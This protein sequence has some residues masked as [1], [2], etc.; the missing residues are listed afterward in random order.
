MA[1]R[2]VAAAY[3]SLE[4]QTAQFKAAIGEAGGLTKKFA[5]ET[6]EQM[7]QSRESVRLL[8]EELGLGIPRGLQGIISKLPGV[9]TAMNAAFDAVVV[10]A[11]I[12]TVVKVTEKVLE[13]SRKNEEAAKK[14][15]AAW[16]EAHGKLEKELDT[17]TVTGDK[18]DETYDKMS[19]KPGNALALAL[20]E[21][22]VTA[23]NLAE[24]L[25]T[26]LGLMDQLFKDQSVSKWQ[27]LLGKDTSDDISQDLEKHRTAITGAERIAREAVRN[28]KTPE[29]QAAATTT[30]QTNVNAAI[31]AALDYIAAKH[32]EING[33]VLLDNGAGVAPYAMVHGNQD[34]HN[35][36]LDGAKDIVENSGDIYNQQIANA[37]KVIRNQKQS[38]GTAAESDRLKSFEDTAKRM[39]EL[40]GADALA[41]AAYW[42]HLVRTN[43]KGSKSFEDSLREH[44]ATAGVEAM[45]EVHGG[46][47]STDEQF[48][49]FRKSLIVKNTPDGIGDTSDAMQKFLGLGGSASDEK[50]SAELARG[51]EAYARFAAELDAARLKVSESTGAL[52]PHAAALA[53][54]AAHAKAYPAELKPLNEQLERLKGDTF[55]SDGE[56][57][58]QM[59]AVGN[60]ISQVNYKNQLQQVADSSSAFDSSF[61]GQVDKTFDDIIAKSQDWGTQFKETITGALGDV[62][63]AIIHILTTKPQAGDHPFKEAGKQIFTGVARTG[64]Q[65][66]E[67]AL[68]KGL[69]LDKIG[70]S[71]ANPMWVRMASAMK[72]AG[73]AVSTAAQAA[74]STGFGGVISSLFSMLIPRAGGGVMSPGDFYMTG[75]QGPELMQVGSTSKINSARDTA[76]IMAGGKGGDTTHVWNI[77][78]K[79]SNDPAAVNAAVQRGIRA[80][81]PQIAAAANAGAKDRIARRPASS[82]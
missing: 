43:Q 25:K 30:G 2:K 72:G 73:S 11:L 61:T 9:T 23:D 12:D 39:K 78:A 64:L 1:S 35:A 56:R 20:D 28:A 34:K 45:K 76:S 31:K 75:E 52:T 40:Q 18:L 49:E 67:G 57:Q 74:T 82:R 46:G 14:T 47:K 62:N 33:N 59:M 63:N 51:G 58:S 81:A 7:Q 48:A 79:G 6:R 27:V 54:A 5:A 36:I 21:A 32:T 3:V 16:D 41:L 13:F 24:S 50:I 8:S 77:D 4:L 19:K 15:A 42:E 53:E 22:K 71:E 10:F 26:D 68:M 37:G 44:S 69:K 80:A 38:D 66:A 17:L 29:D 70:T 55:L 60:Q 65:D